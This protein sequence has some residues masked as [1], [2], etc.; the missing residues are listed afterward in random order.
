ME[1]TLNEMLICREERAN[2]QKALIKKHKFPVVSFTMNIAGPLKTSKLIKRGFH[3]GLC[4]LL[5]RIGEN[6]C[7]KTVRHLKTGDEAFISVDLPPKELKNICTEIEE[8]NALGR[9]FDM[10][11]I[12]QNGEKLS[13]RCERGCIV[14]GKKGRLC[15]ASRAH[16][17][18]ELFAVTNNILTEYFK[19]KDA[20]NIASIAK[21]SLIDEVMTTP[22]AGL[23]DR[24]NCG[25]HTDMNI[26]SFKKSADALKPYFKKCVM[27]GIENAEKSAEETFALL[28]KAGLEAEK[29]MYTATS[30]VNTHKGAVY[31]FGL[32]LG[33][34]G[35]LYL[36]DAPISETN[37]ILDTCVKLAERSVF[38]DLKNARGDTAGEKLYLTHNIKGIRGEALSGFASVK[39]IAL[40]AFENLILKGHSKNDAAAFCLVHLIANIEDSTLYKRGG[41]NGARFAK[42][43]AQTLISEGI[44]YEKLLK[45]DEE[46]IK[47]NLSA[48]GAAD[49]LA[50]TLFIYEIKQKG[51]F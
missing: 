41:E 42:S 27:I 40:P 14:C 2:M 9:L 5:S 51:S 48:G 46:F 18:K 25:S 20:E 34:I 21:K 17:S 50:L 32:I 44:T 11:V 26:D 30:G 36:P 24:N 15:A 22:K 49:L 13:R 16:T 39:N 33:A 37:D 47:R 1:V 4:A 28:R 10:D 31:S 12:A 23:V 45:M 43:Y 29:N 7:E 8:L 38:D 19:E 35:R 6:V 3:E